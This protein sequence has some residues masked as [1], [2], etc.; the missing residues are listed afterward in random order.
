[1]KA[2]I[3]T[4]GR[5]TRMQPLTFS[6]NKHFIPLA[7]KPLIHF[8]IEAVANSG[9]KKVAITY[10]P[11]WLDIVKSYLGDGRRWGLKFT[12]ILQEKPAGLANIFQVCEDYL[13]GES[14]LLHLGDNIFTDGINDLVDNFL[15]NKPDGMIAKVKHPENWRLGVPIFDKKGRLTNY[16]EKPK[17]PPN[18][19]AVP[20]IYFFTNKVFECF[21]GKDKVKPSP[22]GEYEIL[23]PF[24]WLIKH[25]YKVDVVEY[26]GKWLDPG[27]F[28]DW[29]QANQYLLDINVKGK[30]LSKTS[31]L[32]EGRV[33]LG[34]R[35]KLVNSEVRGPVVIGDDVVIK[36]SY[37]GPFTS[38]SDNCV[39]E[40]SHVEN[41]VLM[42]GVVIKN[43][44]KPINES[45]VGSGAEIVN[46]E[47]GPTDWIKLFVGER[48]RVK[49]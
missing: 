24:K 48:S 15:N 16:I 39:I 12:Y 33:D 22:R 36:N 25:K 37:I 18:E 27:K 41:S 10:N 42:P 5:G 34:K 47:N 8:P 2:I 35:T 45:V 44:K 38:V 20:G 40:E 29:I 19:Y 14:F 28:D 9:I 1:M 11:G 6:T 13:K 17:N 7:G 31:S 49:I 46:N 3:P 32:V 30:L 23:E 4:G 43:I 21:K 26:K